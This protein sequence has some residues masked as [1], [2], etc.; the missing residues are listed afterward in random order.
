MDVVDKIK[1]GEPVVNPT[2]WC[3]A[4]RRRCQMTT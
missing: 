2:G 4:G 3:A 1:K